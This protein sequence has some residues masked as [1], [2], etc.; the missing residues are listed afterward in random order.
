MG[1]LFRRLVLSHFAR[2]VWDKSAPEFRFDPCDAQYVSDDEASHARPAPVRRVAQVRR[3]Q[4]RELLLPCP[5]V[6]TD[7]YWYPFK[8]FLPDILR[9]CPIFR[10]A[11]GKNR[12]ARL[13]ESK[14]TDGVNRA[15]KAKNQS[16]MRH[17][18]ALRSENVI[19]L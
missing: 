8:K 10:I 14:S 4:A 1:F 12:Q 3:P 2:L 6:D 9:R 17:V 19:M 11:D 5:D 7:S 15:P 13:P 16:V 18:S